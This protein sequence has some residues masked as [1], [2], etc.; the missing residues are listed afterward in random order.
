VLVVQFNSWLKA[1]MSQPFPRLS[2][3]LRVNRREPVT[4]FEQEC[5]AR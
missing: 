3:G 1:E 2:D 5:F 4:K